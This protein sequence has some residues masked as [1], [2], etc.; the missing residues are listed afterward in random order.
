MRTIIRTG[1]SSAL[2]LSLFCQGVLFAQEQ[3]GDTIS[4]DE[5][6]IT[7]TKQYRSAGNVTQ[8]IDI[9]GNS[10]ME[11]AVTGNNNIAEVLSQKPGISVSALSRND[12]NWGT[13][14]GIGPKYSTYML[15]GLP[16]DAF[17]DPMSLDLKVVERVEIQRGPASVLYPNYL[18]QDFS[19]NQSPLA[20]T[21]NL[22]LKESIKKRESQLLTSYGSYNTL[23]VQAYHQDSRE[24][25]N[26]FAGINFENSDYTDYGTEDSWLNM[27]K[28]PEY[29]KLKLY[30]G[31]NYFYGTG[32]KNKLSIFLNK[33][34][35]QG[36]AGR[37]YR[38][39]EHDYTTVN[40]S[41][42]SEITEALTFS[43]SAGM[44]IYDRT[45]QESNYN[46]IDS[47]VSDNGAN[48]KIIP[49]DANLT[50]EHGS[51]HLLT[52]GADYQNA[53]YYTWSDPLLGYDQYGNKSR[54]F[55]TGVYLQEEMRFGGFTVRGGLRYNYIRTTI[56]LISG[57]N[58]G[59]RITEYNNLLWSAGAKYTISTFASLFANAGNSFLP[60]GLKS[61]GGTISLDDRGVAG[62]HGQLPNPDLKPESGTGGD[63]GVNLT[64]IASL[65]LSLRGFYMIVDDAIIENVVSEDPSQTQS[66]N[67]GSTSSGGFE[68]EAKQVIN[69]NFSW[70]VNYTYMKTTIK[71]DIDTDQDGATVPFAPVHVA[72]AGILFSADF[73]LTINPVL[74]YNDGYYDSSSK[75]GRQEF[76]PGALVNLYISQM[77]ADKEHFNL[78]VFFRIYNL[79]DNR[80]EMPWQFQNTGIAVTGGFKVSFK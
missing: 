73:G 50:W 32:Q 5:V 77:I 72:N 1:L 69:K 24:N 14:T 6:V 70:F 59:D 31:V 47:L 21:V 44:R 29:K 37:I 68:I 12:A 20:G 46:E 33:T 64:L 40:I 48:Q 16:L 35:H 19:G 67:A 53:Q 65:D 2:C 78:D 26:Y 34:R 27:H 15:N 74:N 30:T 75:S 4:I 56:D 63:V 57:G 17:V 43:A 22:I 49:V 42:T 71:N 79:T 23:N 7:G 38:G 66:V 61:M 28:D 62:M 41:Q 55:Q 80:Y 52:V 8:K 60:P 18:S 3:P 76:T 36:D 51:G 58:P 9:I 25:L 13:Y 39:F 54:A 10:E 11:T 45:W